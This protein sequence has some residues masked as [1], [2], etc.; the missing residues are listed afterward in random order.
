MK[1][2]KLLLISLFVSS[3]LFAHD[4]G[5]SFI[6]NNHQWDE[7]IAYK[8]CLPGGALFLTNH[9]I[10]YS[11][12]SLAD[13]NVIHEHKHKRLN[14]LN[15]K[16]HFHAYEVNFEGANENPKIDGIDAYPEYQNYFLGNNPEHW[17]GHVPLYKKV[18]YRNL[19]P[20]IDLMMYSKETKFK[21]DF[22]VAA[23]QDPSKIKLV[24]KGVTPQLKANGDL[25]IQTSVNEIT[26]LAPYAYQL[27]NGQ[28]VPVTCH[29]SLKKNC[30]QYLFP[31]DYNH[32]YPLVIDPVLIF[33]TYSGSLATTY[34]YS[35]TYDQTGCLYAGGECFNTGWPVTLGAFQLTY[36]GSIDASIN[37]Y[38]AV[39]NALV[40]STYFGGSGFDVPNNLV[41]NASNELIIFGTTISSNL[42][43]TAG[44]YDVTANGS[45]DMYVAHFNNTGSGLIGATYVGGSGVDGSNSF[46]LSPNYGDENRGEVFIDAAQNIICTGSTTSTNFPVTAGCYQSALAGSQD[47]VVFKLNPTCTTLLLS[48]YIGGSQD[49]ACFAVNV[50][51]VGNIIVVGG[52]NSTNYPTTAGTLHT[53]SQG[54]TDGFVSILNPG[55]T[56]LIASTYLG[57]S[58][59]DHAFKLQVDNA[60]NVYVCGQTHGAYP[61]TAG[62]YSNPNA[63]IFFDKLNPS[64]TASL[65]S[66]RIGQNTASGDLVPTAF[67][68]DNCGNVYFSGFQASVGLPL[69]PNAFQV[70]QGGFWIC[71][72]ELN[73]TNLLYATYMG[74][75]GDHVDGGTSRFDPQGIIYQSVCTASTN[76][77]NSAGAWSPTNQSG[78]WDVASFKFDFEATGVHAAI[79]LA[80]GSNDTMCAPAAMQFVNNSTGATTYTWDFGDGSPLVTTISP[81]HV[82]TNPGNYTVVLKAFNP[83]SCITEDSAYLNVHIISVQLPIIVV[84][85]TTVC[86]NS[87]TI[88]LNASVS[89]ITTSMYIHWEPIAAILGSTT[90]PTITADPSIS[91]TFTITVIDSVSPSCKQS[92]QAII[93]VNK[94]D[95]SQFQVHPTDT[96]ICK[97]DRITL[98][99]MGGTTYAWW[100]NSNISDTS[101]AIVLVQVASPITYSVN[102]KDVSGCSVTRQVHINTYDVTVDAGNE[103]VIRYGE[104]I[105]LHASGSWAYLWSSDPSLSSLVI[106]DPIASPV[107]TT[108]YYVTGSNAEG[109]TA[110]DSVLIHVANAIIPNAFSPN[111]DGINDVLH[112]KISDHHVALKSMRIFNRW[113]TEVF[114]SKDVNSGWDGRYKGKDCELGVYFYLIEYS[115]GSKSYVDKGDVTLIR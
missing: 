115:I 17:A 7:S 90:T 23:H 76:Q 71:V 64:L 25:Q 110:V 114:S 48:T 16:V 68:Y 51:S 99:A 32:S 41:V 59:Y 29:F 33:A 93:H 96:T 1:K 62:L 5:L 44:A 80:A 37:K 112:F 78:S 75:G 19:Y 73:M 46:W 2:I 72:L 9:S 52:T 91:S 109:C 98:T 3:T 88:L 13:L 55:C 74:S 67:L 57:T 34:G 8:A 12:Y 104:S 113:G 6:Q 103:D 97:N 36:G 84:K 24:F 18:Q 38:T 26:E 107:I 45:N 21:Y 42:P 11:F 58:D 86:D 31:D 10:R 35:A 40:Y 82:Y 43:V 54:G 92:A 94:S 56:A 50:N 4:S 87:S 95:T 65:A 70:N 28:E 66:T 47:G 77:Y 83:L 14:V 111:G 69:T 61:V 106:P 102:I 79:G 49:D 60:D 108:Q 101:S 22:L 100:P 85:D 30:L 89:N 81:T 20:G 15:E 39:G 27:I 63:C 105:Q 53:A